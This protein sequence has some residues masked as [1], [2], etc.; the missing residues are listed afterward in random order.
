M[1]RAAESLDE[2][3]MLEALIKAGEPAPSELVDAK[4]GSNFKYDS[5]RNYLHS[6]P[7]ID[8]HVP[9]RVRGDCILGPFQSLIESL[10]ASEAAHK[11]LE[12]QT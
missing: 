8:L 9:H 3:E 11:G 12:G 1:G 7:D 4:E 5:L 6:R 2:L 10:K